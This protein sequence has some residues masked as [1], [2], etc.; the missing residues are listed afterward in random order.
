MKPSRYP[1]VM[2]LLPAV[3]PW[4]ELSVAPRGGVQRRAAPNFFEAPRR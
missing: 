3:V 2:D 4:R 1:S